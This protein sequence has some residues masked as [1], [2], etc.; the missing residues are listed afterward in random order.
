[1]TLL[2]AAIVS[3]AMVGSVSADG[4][5]DRRTVRRVRPMDAWADE[6]LDRGLLR[7][8]VVRTLVSELEHTDVI[9]HVQTVSTLP[10]GTAGQTRLSLDVGSCRYIR[11]QLARALLPDERAAILAH[12]L[13]HA[14]EL[15]RAGA[16]DD[17]DVRALYERIGR[18]VADGTFETA[19]A[20]D[21]GA[22]AWFE[23]RGVPHP[24]RRTGGHRD[25]EA[26]RR[27]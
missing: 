9:V 13:Q 15:A 4:G 7:S 12:E 17:H 20:R 14:A 19:E 26:Q 16:R 2:L 25:R 5:I 21:A 1:M 18:E 11:I 6:S 10:M 24:G 27:H 22:R 3:M 23:Q 8:A